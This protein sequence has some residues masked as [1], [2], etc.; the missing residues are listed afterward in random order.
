[1]R[2]DLGE[3]ERL[4]GVIKFLQAIE[5]PISRWTALRLVDRLYKEG[6][7]RLSKKRAIST[8]WT[9]KRL[10]SIYKMIKRGLELGH[11]FVKVLEKGLN[12][13]DS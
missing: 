3:A 9:K 12:M 8:S 1:M 2:S 5:K 10:I 6:S 13:L 4:E 7:F 11:G